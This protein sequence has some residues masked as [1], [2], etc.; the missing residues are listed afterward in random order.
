MSAEQ[1]QAM[2]EALVSFVKTEWVEGPCEGNQACASMPCTPALHQLTRS[3][4]Q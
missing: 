2:Y 1:L 3:P 4:A